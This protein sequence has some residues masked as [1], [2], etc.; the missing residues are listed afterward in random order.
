MDALSWRELLRRDGHLELQAPATQQE[1]AE[2]ERRLGAELPVELR[3]LYEA[4]NGAFHTL[5]Q[6]FVL[7]RLE[8]VADRNVDAWI[9]RES[10]ERKKYLGFGDDGTGSPYCVALDGEAAVVTWSPILQE[11]DVLAPTLREF[12]LSWLL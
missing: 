11:A 7:W 2:V 3:G 8:D 5:G 4:T 1:I 10:A 6:W 12:C 9:G